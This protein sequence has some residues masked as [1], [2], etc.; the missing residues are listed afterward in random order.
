MSSSLLLSTVRVAKMSHFQETDSRMGVKEFY[1]G[2][3]IFVTGATGFMGKV[4]VEKL[5]RSIPDIG[6]VYIL[7]RQKRGKTSKERLEDLLSS[8]VSDLDGV[9]EG[10][11][12]KVWL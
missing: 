2:K 3:G 6:N 11:G 4:L 1:A 9:V 12:S 10:C 8:R 7:V 5:L